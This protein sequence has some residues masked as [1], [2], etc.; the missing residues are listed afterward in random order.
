MVV[1]LAHRGDGGVADGG[2]ALMH[3][4]VDCAVAPRGMTPGYRALVRLDLE[5]LCDITWIE[6]LDPSYRSR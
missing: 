6:W 3:A 4:A 5:D 1:S 2:A